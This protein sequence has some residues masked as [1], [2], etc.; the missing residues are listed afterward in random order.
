MGSKF[1]L[2]NSDFALPSTLSS[3]LGRTWP[4]VKLCVEGRGRPYR[5]YHIQHAN[6]RLLAV[7]LKL[8]KAV[9]KVVIRRLSVEDLA[10]VL[11]E[12]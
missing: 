1:A 11:P 5:F 6:Q 8:T 7:L 9:G 12:E 10:R 2:G 3:D 4:H